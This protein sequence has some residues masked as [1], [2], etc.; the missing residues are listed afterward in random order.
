MVPLVIL[1]QHSGV[2][3]V[4][5]VSTWAAVSVLFAAM[6]LFRPLWRVRK[7]NMCHVFF[8]THKQRLLVHVFYDR[9]RS[10]LFHMIRLDAAPLLWNR[11]LAIGLSKFNGQR[12]CAAVRLVFLLD[13]VGKIFFAVLLVDGEVQDFTHG[14]VK[15]R[16]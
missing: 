14:H 9:F 12:G 2:L 16:S 1:A 13:P 11:G 4:G 3:D 5:R 10:L 8:D 15:Q 6:L 7:D